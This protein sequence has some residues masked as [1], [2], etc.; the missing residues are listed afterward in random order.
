MLNPPP[1][2]CNFTP[3]KKV[4]FPWAVVTKEGVEMAHKLLGV[5]IGKESELAVHSSYPCLRI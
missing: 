3:A 2:L 5:D 4:V 1:H